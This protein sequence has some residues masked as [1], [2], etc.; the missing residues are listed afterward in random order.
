MKLVKPLRA[1]RKKLLYDR[2]IHLSNF[3]WIFGISGIT[4]LEKIIVTS[5]GAAKSPAKIQDGEACN[6]QNSP[7]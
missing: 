4:K 3:E 2:K 7:P 5:K 1:D 6:N